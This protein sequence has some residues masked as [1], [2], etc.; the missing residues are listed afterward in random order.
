MRQTFCNMSRITSW[1]HCWTRTSLPPVWCSSWSCKSECLAPARFFF[2]VVSVFTCFSQQ[3]EF[4]AAFRER[5]PTWFGMNQTRWMLLFNSFHINFVLFECF[6][7]VTLCQAFSTTRTSKAN[8]N[9]WHHPFTVNELQSLK[10]IFTA[11]CNSGSTEPVIQPRSAEIETCLCFHV[12]LEDGRLLDYLVA[13]DEL[14]E[15]KVAFFIRETLEALEHLHTCRV[16]H[17]DLKVTAG[18]CLTKRKILTVVVCSSVS[19]S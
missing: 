3:V 8:V 5:V 19:E 15:E 11:V 16:A 2:I 9:M 18:S 1:C 6:H 7:N 10:C 14:M 4:S 13:H 17:L 12:R